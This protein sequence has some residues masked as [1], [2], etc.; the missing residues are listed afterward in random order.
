MIN[1]ILTFV[2]FSKIILC[3]LFILQSIKIFKLQTEKLQYKNAKDGIKRAKE[4]SEKGNIRDYYFI[5]SITEAEINTFYKK[6]Y[7]TI[8][9]WFVLLCVYSF[10]LTF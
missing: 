4:A 3:I 1:E 6:Y 2:G 9:I 10:L 7:L 5:T 8:I